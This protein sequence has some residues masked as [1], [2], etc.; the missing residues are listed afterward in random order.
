MGKFDV[1]LNKREFPNCSAQGAVASG[2]GPSANSFQGNY[3]L[4]FY[5]D[6]LCKKE[7]EVSTFSVQT[8]SRFLWRVYRGA[9]FCYDYI[10]QTPRNSS[11]VL[12]RQVAR[13]VVN[14]K[15]VCGN[16]DM[17]GNDIRIQRFQGKVCS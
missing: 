12:S 3:I 9:E 1:A 13:N 15:L 7:F 11:V 10:D 5:T 2:D 17:S 8:A 14:F 6:P 16:S 4:Q